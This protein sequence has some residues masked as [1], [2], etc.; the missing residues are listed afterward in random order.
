LV[1]G[2]PTW[3]LAC[4]QHRYT[5]RGPDRRR[6]NNEQ[7]NSRLK[8]LV[9]ERGLDNEILKEV[10]AKQ[11]DHRPGCLDRQKHDSLAEPA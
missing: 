2:S 11:L 1:C 8:K 6:H 9:A 10:A 3:F 7:E 5:T 4:R